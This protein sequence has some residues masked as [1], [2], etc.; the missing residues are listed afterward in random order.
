[1]M[2]IMVWF[3]TL[4]TRIQAIAER[5]ARFILPVAFL[6]GLFWDSL[7][8]RRPDSPFE[9]A[10]VIAYL[11]LSAG[12]IVI[13]NLRR[14]RHGIDPSLLMLGFLQFAFGNLTSAL[15][16]LYIKSGT[17][18][19]SALFFAV[20]GIILV[21]N[22]FISD[23]YSR[24][25]V[26]IAVWYFLILSYFTIAI[27]ILAGRIGDVMYAVSIVASIA[28][29]SLLLAVIYAVAARPLLER[30]WHIATAVGG[31]AVLMSALY[32][33]GNTPPA[34]LMLK[35]IGMYHS[36]T[37]TGDGNYIGTYE[38]ARWYQ[39]FLNTSNAYTH[40]VGAS[41]Y[42]ASAVFAPERLSTLIFHRWEYYDRS[43]EKWVTTLR[44]P[45]GIQGGRATG[46]R[47][48]SHSAALKPGKWRCNVET[49]RGALIGR[50]SFLV[51]AGAPA[52]LEEAIF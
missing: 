16:V 45:L 8:L 41:A 11:L 15:L 51:V 32:F 14:A 36:V 10:T 30:L 46:Y 5:H 26:H 31:I 20:F 7:T 27:P 52:S 35:H 12:A 17:L 38:P 2:K 44:I 22:E 33:T 28:A 49:A 13:L 43:Q 34:P 29:V 19:G 25:Q 18:V 6:W 40:A 9:N 3:L 39:F 47:G 21:G 4:R 42:C 1:M 24:V 23:K 37:R 48:Y 50:F